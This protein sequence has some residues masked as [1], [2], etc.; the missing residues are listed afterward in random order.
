MIVKL[1]C[2]V[3]KSGGQNAY[4]VLRL[5]VSYLSFLWGVRKFHL[6]FFLVF[7]CR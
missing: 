2:I 1:L 3:V 5:N 7:T 6:V 4:F